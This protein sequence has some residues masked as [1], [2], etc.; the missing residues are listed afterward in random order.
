MYE[1]PTLPLYTNR[2]DDPKSLLMGKT[3]KLGQRCVA[4]SGDMYRYISFVADDIFPHLMARVKPSD[5]LCTTKL[6]LITFALDGS[7]NTYPSDRDIVEITPYSTPD[8]EWAMS[9]NIK[10]MANEIN[11]GD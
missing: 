3:M 9:F 4:K 11:V 5:N 6:F 10:K 1:L 8:E 7:W 2:I